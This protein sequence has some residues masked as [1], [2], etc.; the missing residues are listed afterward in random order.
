MERPEWCPH[1]DCKFGTQSQGLICIG[2]LPK[3]ELHDKWFNT[4]RFCLNTSETG[5]GIFDLQI[6]WG[7]AWNMIRILNTIEPT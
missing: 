6:N 3:P 5:H 1:K 4:H 2:E 7:D